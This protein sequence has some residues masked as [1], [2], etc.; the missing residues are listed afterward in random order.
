LSFFIRAVNFSALDSFAQRSLDGCQDSVAPFCILLMLLVIT[1]PERR[2]DA[3]EY[4]N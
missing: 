4:Q 1:E 3:N 2:V